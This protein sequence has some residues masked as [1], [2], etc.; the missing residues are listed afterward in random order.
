MRDRRDEEP[1]DTE[2]P[3]SVPSDSVH[4][5]PLSSPFSLS[6][7]IHFGRF[8]V[9]MSRWSFRLSKNA[10]SKKGQITQLITQPAITRPPQSLG[11][12]FDESGSKK[13]MQMTLTSQPRIQIAA[14][15]TSIHHQ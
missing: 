15:P 9:C 13:T 5:R 3:N 4:L 2:A 1:P 11:F 8:P 6:R 14:R 12:S 7:T 10:G